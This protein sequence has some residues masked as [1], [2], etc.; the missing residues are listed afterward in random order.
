MSTKT[1]R[2]ITLPILGENETVAEYVVRRQAIKFHP[3]R[4]LFVLKSYVPEELPTKYVKRA[5]GKWERVN[6]TCVVCYELTTDNIVC[7]TCGAGCC[8]MCRD[9]NMKRN[10]DDE[11]ASFDFHCFVCREVIARYN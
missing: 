3:S 8:S 4:V 2:Y 10:W 7:K 5:T 11:A 9:E 6:A 1:I